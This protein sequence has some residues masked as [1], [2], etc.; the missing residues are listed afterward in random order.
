VRELASEL[1]EARYVSSEVSFDGVDDD[2]ETVGADEAMTADVRIIQ[3]PADIPNSF[4]FA[5]SYNDI[6]R[7]IAK[8]NSRGLTGEWSEVMYRKFNE[9][10]LFCA[11]SFQYNH[12][13]RAQSQ[14]SNL[15]FLVGKAKCRTGDCVQV[16]LSIQNEPVEGQEVRVDL[17]VTGTCQHVR[18]SDDIVVERPNR[19]QL[20]SAARANAADLLTSSQ[21]SATELHY[22]RL[23]EMSDE[24]CR[25]A[26]TTTCQTPAVFRQAAYERRR[27]QQ[28]HE[29]VVMELDIAREC[30]ADSIPGTHISG[31]IQ[32]LGLFPFHV[33]FYTEQQVRA[34]VDKCRSDSGAVAHLDA[35]GSIVSRI[36]GQKRTL[37]Y[38]FLLGEDNLP[39]LDFLSSCHEGAWLQCL[40][41]TFNSAVRR[42]NSGRLL[43]PRYV[44][45]DFSYALIHA[46]INAFNH[47]MQ[48]ASYLSTT[49]RIMCCNCTKS[50]LEGM[51][52][53]SLCASHVL[54]SMSVKLSKAETNKHTRQLAMTYFAALQRTVDL[55]SAAQTYRDIALVLCSER[56]TESV[57]KA[58]VRL[59]A[60]VSGITVDVTDD[61]HEAVQEDDDVLDAADV[62]TLKAQSPFT[63]YFESH[64][65]DVVS[66]VDDDA[67]ETLPANVTIS[68][69][70]FEQVHCD[71]T[72]VIFQ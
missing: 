52:F 18:N 14:K 29:H 66:G 51:T 35:T 34:Y 60:T 6:K 15:P 26:N 45:T 37:Y 33:C 8:R 42:C 43:T 21:Q 28:L 16:T 57:T 32:Q 58:R 4:S 56:E 2:S 59:Q 20:R 72:N 27:S 39:I 62:R 69:R 30:W 68:R 5:L 61:V 10:Y 41:T 1:P 65:T 11:L 24:E 67:D 12:V 49:Y 40:L 36:T 53:L 22:Q 70:S 13:R 46:C 47:G 19:R 71:T 23:G 64:V 3:T 38:C 54:K 9:V 31:Y 7:F 48:I 17:E 44:V 50:Q 63:Q 55:Q 25:A